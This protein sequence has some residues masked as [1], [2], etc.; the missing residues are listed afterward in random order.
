MANT[1]NRLSLARKELR[2]ELYSFADE[3]LLPATERIV[4]GE[5]SGAKDE[6]RQEIIT[7]K[8]EFRQEMSAMKFDIVDK[9]S[10]LRSD[11]LIETVIK[12]RFVANI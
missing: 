2:E 10:E 9:I 6:L 12:S 7:T 3:L 8:D 1:N 5:V 11:I 4:K